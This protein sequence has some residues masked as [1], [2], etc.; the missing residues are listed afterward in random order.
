MSCYWDLRG[1]WNHQTKRK[2]LQRIYPMYDCLLHVILC[3]C[4]VYGF[5]YIKIWNSDYFAKNILLQRTVWSVSNIGYTD[6][7]LLPSCLHPAYMTPSLTWTLHSTQ[8]EPLR[9]DKPVT[10]EQKDHNAFFIFICAPTV[11]D[12]QSDGGTE[13]CLCRHPNCHTLIIILNDLLPIAMGH[14]FEDI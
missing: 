11:H 9:R 5:K 2:K 14:W 13:N 3:I 1:N 12:L 7:A 4:M 6:R 10:V 8:K